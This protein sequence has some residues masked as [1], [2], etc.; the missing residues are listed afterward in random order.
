L[1]STFL[2]LACSQKH[3]KKCFRIILNWIV[4]NFIVKKLHLYIKTIYKLI[5]LI[6]TS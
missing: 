2:F 3:F 4:I 6:L 1:T 5:K